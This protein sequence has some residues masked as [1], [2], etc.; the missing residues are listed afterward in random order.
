M[1]ITVWRHTPD[2][3]TCP[4]TTDPNAP[5]GCQQGYT[6]VVEQN[7]RVL[8]GGFDSLDDTLDWMT[9]CMGRACL[10]EE[11]MYFTPAMF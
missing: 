4:P 7:G 3:C 6:Y 2:T 1:S 8:A 11:P 9:S 10:K 5:L